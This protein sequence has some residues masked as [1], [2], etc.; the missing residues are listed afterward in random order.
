MES[1]S[2]L[3]LPPRPLSERPT[4]WT[5]A[6]R[7]YQTCQ[8]FS[9]LILTVAVI[10]LGLQ[11][12][13]LK[14]QLN[15][16]DQKIEDLLE[17]IR[18]QQDVQQDLNTRVDNE[19]SFTLYQ[20]AGTFTLLSCLL[21]AFHMTQHVSNF[22]E[23]EI[24]RKI[25]AILWMS[26]IYSIT[27]FV[28][29]VA[30]T[31]DGYLEVLKD[32]YEAYVVYTFLSFL[33]AVLGRGD[34]ETAVAVLAKHADH[35]K[36]PTTCLSSCYH[37]PPDTSNE[38]K[39]NAVLM[40]CQILAMQFVMVRPVTSILLFISETFVV[41]PPDED[42]PYHYF[43]SPNFYIAMITNV[44]VFFAFNG[45]LKFYHAVHD[46]LRWCKPFSKFMSIK[47]IVFL[48]FWQGLLIS[49]IVNLHLQTTASNRSASAVSPTQL[50]T[51]AP[52]TGTEAPVPA[53]NRVLE[54]EEEATQSSNQLAA[55]IQNFLICLEML[56][57]SIAHWC[58]FPA[59][60]WSPDYRPK[61]H[62]VKPGI[63]FKD[64]ASDLKYIVST[65]KTARRFRREHS[66]MSD[67]QGSRR[68]D[69]DI[70]EREVL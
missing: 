11:I 37:P 65:S 2:S 19:H 38:A 58:V 42:D 6:V 57:F 31:A 13:W 8:S 70:S 10:T 52:T 39:A 41:E 24:Q 47:G 22:Q 14:G 27:S 68:L 28:G 53:P 62:V 40:E 12:H 20:V 33:I 34:R 51:Y 54:Q 63:G 43:K 25:V 30:P 36:D 50:A 26:P 29:L 44:S 17:Q 15:A 23:P 49:I 45:L 1:S 60:E 67:S 21:T 3:E 48:T 46:D 32:F 18:N 5:T 7:V 35:L 4:F 55:Q 61:Q 9:F 56:F 64:F 59:E 69:E 66:N 16:E